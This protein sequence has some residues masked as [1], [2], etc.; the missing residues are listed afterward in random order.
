MLY[1]ILNQA[2]KSL[3]YIHYT[4]NILISFGTYCVYSDSQDNIKTSMKMS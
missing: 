2:N 3:R 4:K 1:V